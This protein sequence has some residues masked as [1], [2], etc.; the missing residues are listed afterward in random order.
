MPQDPPTSYELMGAGLGAFFRP[1]DLEALGLGQ[2][3][4]RKL[5]QSGVAE[6]V[7]HG[8]YRLVEVEPSEHYTLA[9]V[10]AGVPSAVVCLLSA[11]RYHEIGTQLPREVWIA[12]AHKARAPRLPKFPVHLI[13]FSGVR[14]RYGVESIQLEGVPARITNPARTVVDCFRR[15]RLVG[16]NVALEALREAV[17]D[18]KATREEIWRA[19]DVCG[20]KST[21][22]PYLEALSG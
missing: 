2:S 11:L 20:G 14:L 1:R 5:T 8:L 9:A 21:I 15:M 22:G 3:D 7:S 12:I 6:R 18:R 4:L 10:C 16:K 13:R 19:A 17:R